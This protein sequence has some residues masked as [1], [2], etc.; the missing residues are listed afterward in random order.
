MS[1]IDHSLKYRGKNDKQIEQRRRVRHDVAVSLRKNKKED[2]LAKRRNIVISPNDTLDGDVDHS[3][4]EKDSVARAE[5]ADNLPDSSSGAGASNQSQP[6]ASL[7]PAAPLLPLPEI[8]QGIKTNV[9]ILKSF[10][11]NS[12]PSLET[13]LDLQSLQHFV[14]QCRKML[15]RE[16]K[17]PIDQV[18]DNG[19]VPELVYLLEMDL[20]FGEFLKVNKNVQ[21]KTGVKKFV[22]VPSCEDVRGKHVICIIFEAAWALRGGWGLGF[23]RRCRTI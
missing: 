1:T 4:S 18:I 21:V 8:T 6:A 20:V 23:L 14:Q 12:E 15:S 7:H 11:A 10:A 13:T 3:D 16:K 9:Q 17:P 22:V 19:I 2:N 5:N